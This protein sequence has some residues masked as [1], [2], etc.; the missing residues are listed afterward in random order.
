[1]DMCQHWDMIE[2][3]SDPTDEETA[4]WHRTMAPVLFNRTWDLLDME[5]RTAADD[6]LMLSAT[7]GQRYHWYQ[8]GTPL[9]KAV[10]DWQVSRVAAV[11]GFADIAER[12]A[13]LSLAICEEHDL[14]A[15]YRG[16]AH[17]ALARAADVMDDFRTRDQHV[18]AARALLSD[19]SDEKER[20]MLDADV[21]MLV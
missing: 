12:F 6:E 17:E 9:N 15:F 21:Q 19:V 20:G 11:L 2:P 16:Y 14:P 18:L 3:V 7:F 8:V 4:R 13:S 5:A 10:A 1:M